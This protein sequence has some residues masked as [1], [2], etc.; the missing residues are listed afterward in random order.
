MARNAAVDHRRR[1]RSVPVGGT[2]ADF[3]G[4]AL[5][6]VRDH[7]GAVEDHSVLA[8]APR[9]LAPAHREAVVRVHVM[10]QAGEDVAAQL[11]VP[12]GTVKSRTQHGVRALRAE[13]ARLGIRGAAA[14][15]PAPTAECRADTLRG[16]RPHPWRR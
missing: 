3:A 10:G 8:G 12:R 6:P 15:A 7:A 14:W 1:D 4:T 13:L 11:G 9:A 5:A 2:A 16:P